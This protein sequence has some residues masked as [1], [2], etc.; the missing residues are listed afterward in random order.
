M[1]EE[2]VGGAE[3]TS[4]SVPLVREVGS[5]GTVLATVTVSEGFPQGINWKEWHIGT[6]HIQLV[7]LRS[8]NIELYP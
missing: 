5:S 3:F 6:S 7:I 8:I 1:E 2:D 4:V